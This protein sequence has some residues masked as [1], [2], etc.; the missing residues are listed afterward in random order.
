MSVC[1]SVVCP[2]YFVYSLYLAFLFYFTYY[3]TVFTVIN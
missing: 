1:V 3:W 2:S